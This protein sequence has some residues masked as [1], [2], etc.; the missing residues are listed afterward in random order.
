MFKSPQS[1]SSDDFLENLNIVTEDISSQPMTL[2]E[3]IDYSIDMEQRYISDYE[4]IESSA[5]NLS[6]EPAQRVVFTGKQGI[7]SLKWMQ[8]LFVKNNVV[9]II[10]YTAMVDSYSSELETIQQ[11]INSLVIH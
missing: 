10:T 1:S 2:S 11:M 6:S 9:Y 8:I 4:L 7:Y 5:F 3:Y